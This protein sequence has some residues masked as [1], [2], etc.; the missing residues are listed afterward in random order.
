[1]YTIRLC[2]GVG[3][4]LLWG[5][6]AVASHDQC[7]EPSATDVDR[8]FGSEL[9]E[10]GSIYYESKI[11]EGYTSSGVYYWC[12]D[13][14]LNNFV[15]NVEWGDEENPTRFFSGY[16]E[17]GH[18][19]VRMGTFGTKYLKE[20]KA[21]R[22]SKKFGGWTVKPVETVY[23]SQN[24]EPEAS[25]NTLQVPFHMA[26]EDG[27]LTATEATAILNEMGKLQL[28]YFG[29]FDVPVG[30]GVLAQLEDGSYTQYNEQD[31]ATIGIGVQSDIFL[32]SG[33]GVTNTLQIDYNLDDRVKA[34]D[35]R[36]EE[37]RIRIKYPESFAG[38]EPSE[39]SFSDLK[40]VEQV[41]RISLSG[42]RFDSAKVLDVSIAIHGPNGIEIGSLPA[43][44]LVPEGF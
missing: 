14:R 22:Y 9:Y 23:A 28:Y 40:A 18:E 44:V 41:S 36:L 5:N 19:R 37:A 31:F 24:S 7:P 1:M 39:F 4:V 43:R 2:L 8:A 13:S 17:P 21:L 42:G 29:S 30:E 15:I 25:A 35:D 10:D 32:D 26:F 20:Q 34:G 3:V 6:L 16:V 38:M 12:V 33:V 27:E 11:E